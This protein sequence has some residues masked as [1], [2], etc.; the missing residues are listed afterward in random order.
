VLNRRGFEDILQ[1]GFAEAIRYGRPAS[2][3]LVDLDHFKA[4]NDSHG[5]LAG[6]RVLADF[7]VRV[8]ALLRRPDSFGRFGGEEFVALLPETEPEAA[9]VVAER[10]RAALETAEEQ[11][12]CTVSI[13]IAV[14]RS[15]DN[16]IDA[17]L[18]RA[19]AALYRAKAGGR[20]RVEGAAADS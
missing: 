17:V 20:N 18:A 15:D 9:R 11:P 14:S 8:A 3:V 6:D 13:G 19:D 7:G 16:A 4:I 12:G 5:H 10:I 2:M 1:R